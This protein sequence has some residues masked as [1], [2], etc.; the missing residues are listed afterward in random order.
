M[1]NVATP[2]KNPRMQVPRFFQVFR[3]SINTVNTS[4]PTHTPAALLRRVMKHTP[5]ANP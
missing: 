2:A 4:T 5:N 1:K 3:I